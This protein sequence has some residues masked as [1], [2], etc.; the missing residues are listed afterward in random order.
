MTTPAIPPPAFDE[1]IIVG[2]APPEFCQKYL[3]AFESDGD[4]IYVEIIRLLFCV[5][6]ALSI[7]GLIFISTTIIYNKKL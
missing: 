6:F 4:D 3:N 7:A 5:L 2:K 1:G